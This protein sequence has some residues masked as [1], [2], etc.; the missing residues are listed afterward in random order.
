MPVPLPT[1]AEVNR[2][3]P[4]AD[5]VRI[6]GRGLMAAVAP[7]T[8]LTD[9][10]KVL[11]KA[12]AHSM[13]GVT[14]EPDELKPIGPDGLAEGLRRRDLI[15]RTRIVQLMLLTELI[16]VPLPDDVARRPTPPRSA[17]MTPCCTSPIA[18]HP[19]P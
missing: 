16:L 10:Q 15:F 1:D 13:T 11:I 14:V 19:A 9:L 2:Q 17:S 18:T 7:T 8:G 3:P 6:I 12:I 4:D 5:E